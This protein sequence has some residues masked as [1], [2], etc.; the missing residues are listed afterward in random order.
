MI[1]INLLGVA[2]PVAQ[3]AGPSEGIAPEAIIIPGA[4]F[5]VLALIAGFV[6]WYLNSQINALGTEL[7]KQQ[8]EKARLAGIMEQ[9]KH[10]EEQLNQLHLRI[11]TIQMLQNSRV[12]PVEMMHV[13]GLL[14]NRSNNLY[15]LSV[16]NT[17]GRLV[18]DGQAS[19]TDAIANFIGSLQRSGSFDDVQ[20]TKS[21]ED[22]QYK[23][24]NFK[25]NL[26]CVF[27]QSATGTPAAPAG[28]GASS[29]APP[30]RRAGL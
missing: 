22:D 10:Y 15:L 9:N 4:L 19:S 1:K 28:Q 5:V 29:P 13:L 12:G 6:Y 18:M 14:A 27:K 2:K 23:R 21:Y 3:A 25:F 11:N 26:N 30:P 24:V 8:R 7:A 16:S 17:A 20:L